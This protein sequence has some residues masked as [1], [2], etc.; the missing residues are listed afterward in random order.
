MPPGLIHIVGYR[1]EADMPPADQTERVRAGFEEL[2][3]AIDGAELLCLGANVSPSV[4]ARGWHYA[5]AIRLRDGEALDAYIAH[6]AHA[7]L[8][9]ETKQGFYDLCAV[10][11]VEIRGSD[12]E[13]DVQ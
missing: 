2:V 11:D 9:A 4:M 10:I 6:P 7:R 1:S 3:D 5:A 12:N 8:G 13:G